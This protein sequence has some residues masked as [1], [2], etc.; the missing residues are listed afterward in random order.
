MAQE[1]NE[2]TLEEEEDDDNDNTWSR[3]KEIREEGY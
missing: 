1:S 2:V 3:E